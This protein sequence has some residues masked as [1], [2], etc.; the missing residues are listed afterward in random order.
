[1]NGADVQDT[2]SVMMDGD[3]QT[4]MGGTPID[5]E[6]LKTLPGLRAVENWTIDA[7]EGL[8]EFMKGFSDRM[9]NR[10]I[11][12]QNQVDDL[13]YET[14]ASEANLYNTFNEFIMLSNTQFIENRIYEEDIEIKQ[15]NEQQQQ[16]AQQQQQQSLSDEEKKTSDEQAGRNFSAAIKYGLKA[17]EVCSVPLEEDD[18]NMNGE[19]DEE[20]EEPLDEEQQRQQQ[21]QKSKMEQ[22]KIENHYKEQATFLKERTLPAII[23]TQEFFNDD[24]VGL[25]PEEEDIRVVEGMGEDQNALEQNNIDN[26]NGV[27]PPPPPPP[28]PLAGTGLAPPPPPPPL[29][30]T[31]LN[32]F[33]SPDGT[34]GSTGDLFGNEEDNLFGTNE[35]GEK[36]LSIRDQLAAA[37]ANK[38]QKPTESQEASHATS[39]AENDNEEDGLFGSNKVDPFGSAGLFG[40]DSTSKQSTLHGNDAFD[41]GE[42]EASITGKKT[43]T[44]NN[45][46]LNKSGFT[47]DFGDDSGGSLFDEDIDIVASKPKVSNIEKKAQTADTLFG[48]DDDDDLDNILGGSLPKKE[49]PGK[50]SV[51]TNAPTPKSSTT[52]SSVKSGGLFSFDDEDDGG[53][54]LSAT[55]TKKT[56][57]DTNPSVP[58][59]SNLFGFDEEDDDLEFLKGTTKDAQEKKAEHSKEA[60][61]ASIKSSLFQDDDEDDFI[62]QAA[63]TEQQKKLTPKQ[64]EASSVTKSSLFGDDDDDDLDLIKAPTKNEQE[65]KTDATKQPVKTSTTAAKSSL[66]EDDADIDFAKKSIKEQEEKTKPIIDSTPTSKSTLFGD[67]EDFN[68]VSKIATKKEEAKETPKHQAAKKMP[69][70]NDDDDLASSGAASKKPESN[71]EETLEKTTKVSK[72]E[73]TKQSQKVADGTNKEKSQPIQIKKDIN[74][75]IEKEEVTIVKPSSLNKDLFAASIMKGL[76]LNVGGGPS[77]SI[78]RIRRESNAEELHKSTSTSSQSSPTVTKASPVEQ[79]T[80]NL[81]PVKKSSGLFDDED[82][83][84]FLAKKSV[85]K[86]RSEI[87]NNSQKQSLE[88]SP[89]DILDKLATKGPTGTSNLFDDIEPLTSKPDQRSTIKIERKSSKDEEEEMSKVSNYARDGGGGQTLTHMSLSRPKRSKKKPSRKAVVNPPKSGTTSNINS[90]QAGMDESKTQSPPVPISIKMNS[91]FDDSA[92]NALDNGSTKAPIANKESNTAPA[93]KKA[94][95]FGDSD[96]EDFLFISKTEKPKTNTSTSASKPSTITKES[97]KVTTSTTSLSPGSDKEQIKL[98]STKEQETIKH[99]T[100]EASLVVTEHESSPSIRREPTKDKIETSE[101]RSISKIAE[102]SSETVTALTEKSDIQVDLAATKTPVTPTPNKQDEDMSLS[103]SNKVQNSYALKKKADMEQKKRSVASLFKDDDL[104]EQPSRKQESKSSK[105]SKNANDLI[106]DLLSDID[107]K[108]VSSKKKPAASAKPSIDDNLF[109]STSTIKKNVSTTAAIDDLLSMPVKKTSTS[110]KKPS[111]DINSVGDAASTSTTKKDASAHKTAVRKAAAKNLFDNEDDIFAAP[112][113][114]KPTQKKATVKKV[115]TSDLFDF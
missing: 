54:F 16:Q 68:F 58:K 26:Q 82:D 50:S 115:D 102:I 84:E 76:N 10:M 103:T 92:P 81:N 22:L 12:V 39:N 114:K 52:V 36:T 4:D 37:M 109:S 87:A 15:Q 33:M 31:Q 95:L 20:E 80:S 57:K 19:L 86:S 27:V 73:E 96:E 13:V 77:K 21:Q 97:S 91:L 3:L 23:G 101:K 64:P 71:I 72:Q 60:P 5:F 1:M 104:M 63:K 99:V 18:M 67:D 41:L 14:K 61:K 85:S 106:D 55:T 24:L 51:A 107:P 53:D 108:K 35:Q 79:E 70:W 34:F 98:T 2:M 17:L 44:T 93:T 30:N 7:D 28:P 100:K 48:M 78:A 94:S 6:A 111:T 32:S 83:L 62:Q 88:N 65:K 74:S 45:Q 75:D 56:G 25:K 112:V 66:F 49:K 59:K 9:L 11:Q 40:T 42:L 46:A 29:P 43:G 89:E 110:S 38:F 113:A 47:F 69:I 90:A 105:S 8:L